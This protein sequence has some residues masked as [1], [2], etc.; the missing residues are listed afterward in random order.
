M[1][2]EVFRKSFDTVHTSQCRTDLEVL[3]IYHKPGT[4]YL[5][6]DTRQPL[7]IYMYIIYY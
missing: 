1:V 4:T 7:H 2:L 5:Y 3:D 6:W